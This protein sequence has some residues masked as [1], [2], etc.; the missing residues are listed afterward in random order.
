MEYRKFYSI[1]S[2][3]EKL[4]RFRGSVIGAS[5]QLEFTGQSVAELR[6]NFAQVVEHHLNECIK[7]GTEPYEYFA[8]KVHVRFAPEDHRDAVLSASIRGMSLNAWM[9]EAIQAKLLAE[10]PR[11]FPTHRGPRRS[12][13]PR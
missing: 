1:L 9:I 6:E 2:L 3:D 4:D 5:R 11:A 12:Q 7:Q 8:G 13:E 10:R